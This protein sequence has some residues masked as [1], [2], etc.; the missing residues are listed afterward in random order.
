MPTDKAWECPLNPGDLADASCALRQSAAVL[1]P[2]LTRGGFG[3]L[4]L[5][6]HGNEEL[7]RAFWPMCEMPVHMA[8]LGSMISRKMAQGIGQGQA[9]ALERATLMQD[10]LIALAYHPYPQIIPPCL[11]PSLC[12]PFCPPEPSS[13]GA[14]AG[15]GDR[16]DGNGPR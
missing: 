6:C 15:L 3:D 8:L 4:R 2:Q 14:R 10:L 13:C 11:S 7:A 16:R 9:A 1:T 12:P 5:V